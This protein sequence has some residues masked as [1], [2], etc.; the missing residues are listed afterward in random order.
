MYKDDSNNT[1]FVFRYSSTLQR[2]IKLD[3]TLK[4][5]SE[6]VEQTQ[7]FSEIIRHGWAKAKLHYKFVLQTSLQKKFEIH[8]KHKILQIIE[9]DTTLFPLST[10]N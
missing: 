1:I 10:K 3:R 5:S 4:F 7:S 9:Q 8:R 6:I 2:Y